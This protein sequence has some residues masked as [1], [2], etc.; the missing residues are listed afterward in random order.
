MQ[1]A[2][3]YIDIL[4]IT[5]F[6][7]LDE[8]I[9]LTKIFISFDIYESLFEPFLTG[10]ILITDTQDLISNFPIIGN[11]K[12]RISLK[13]ENKVVDLV[14]RIYKIDSDIGNTKGLMKFK[15]F[16]LYFCS[17]E[18]LKSNKISKKYEGKA[19]TIIANILNTDK[20]LLY[21]PTANN[22]SFY[23]NFW[24][25]HKIIDFILKLSK[26]SKYY[27][28]VFY[29][30]LENLNFFPI[31]YLQNESPNE[32]II[33]DLSNDH[34]IKNDNI[35]TFK[36]VR[37]FNILESQVYGMFGKTLYNVHE[38]NYSFEK[39]NRDI[40]DVFENITSLGKHIPF[41][42]NLFSEETEIVNNFYDSDISIIR[43]ICL[44]I[45]RHYNIIIKIN[46][47][48]DRKCGQ[49]LKLEFPTFNKN[50][51]YSESFE[52]NWFNIGMHHMISNR[53]L[54]EQNILIGKNAKFNFENLELV[55][56]DKNI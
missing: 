50:E 22:I 53:S 11:E 2:F 45:L 31:S 43:R 44:S 14:F 9:D 47:M 56:G 34:Y 3:N 54:Y 20:S 7:F 33:Y 27:D 38:T 55:K 48:L 4:D 39:K 37:Y 6:N 15:T 49:I 46:G 12:L 29:E 28:Y 52:G 21:F 42:S 36:F 32:T 18:K 10:K 8:S 30:T 24:S 5:L 41:D 25:I 1:P 51:I 40:A 16:V 26:S 17:E 35:K 13:Q 23:S 19:E